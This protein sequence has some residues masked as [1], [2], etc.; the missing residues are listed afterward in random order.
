M[1]KYEYCVIFGGAYVI[2]AESLLYGT[3]AKKIGLNHK[4]WAEIT[5]EDEKKGNC[6]TQRFGNFRS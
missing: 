4:N 3:K 2:R 5:Y 6:S 1:N